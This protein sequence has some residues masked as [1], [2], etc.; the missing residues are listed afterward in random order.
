MVFGASKKSDKKGRDYPAY[1]P[2]KKETV[3]VEQPSTASFIGKTMNIEGGLVSDED[4]T[5]E[6]RVKGTIEVSK[7]LTIG[8]YGDV[9][10]D[11]NARVVKII[12]KARGNI[13]ASDK[14]EILSE[15][16]YNG[17]IMS[18]KLVVA[19]GAVLIGNINQEEENGPV[20]TE[21]GKKKKQK[22][23]STTPPEPETE[24]EPETEQEPTE[25]EKKEAYTAVDTEDANI[26]VDSDTENEEPK[27]DEDSDTSYTSTDK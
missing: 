5:I 26:P 19:E 14:V 23:K 12:G 18:E 15:G 10:A 20:S 22:T 11:I 16:R 8:R 17:N 27:K 24:L 21:T 4:L 3:V 2:P 9:T 13:V 6:G 7:T 1:Q 25:G